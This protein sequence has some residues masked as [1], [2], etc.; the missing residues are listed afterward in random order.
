[1]PS[2]RKPAAGP[3]ADEPRGPGYLRAPG[4][5]AMIVSEDIVPFGEFKAQASRVFKRLHERGRPIVVTQHGRPTAVVMSPAQYDALVA[6]ERFIT[7]VMEGLREAD[8][9]KLIDD[10]DVGAEID[11][12][13]PDPNAR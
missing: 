7:G 10:A 9:G 13:F 6:R 1:M 8:A 2:K 12:W 5:G 4:T 3:S 11:R